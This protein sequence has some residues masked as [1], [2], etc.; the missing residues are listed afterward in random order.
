MAGFKVIK[1]VFGSAKREFGGT[2]YGGGSGG[3]YGGGDMP[4]GGGHAAGGRTDHVPVAVAGGEYC[5][6]PHDVLFAGMGDLAAGH[7]ALDEW[8]LRNRA[9]HIKTLKNLP[10]P[11]RD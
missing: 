1:R 11:K 5:L 8:V 2:P 3:P 4:Y 7:K 10:G 6:A 9:K